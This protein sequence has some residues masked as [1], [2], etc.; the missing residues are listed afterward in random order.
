LQDQTNNL[1]NKAA[2]FRIASAQFIVSLV[3]ALLLLVTL[4]VKAAYSAMLGGTISSVATVYMGLRIF[5]RNYNTAQEML[6]A[7]YVSETIK[8]LFVVALFCMVFILIDVHFL[9][10]VFTYFMTIIVFALA[11]IWPVLGFS[12]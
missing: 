9:S 2:V 6:S 10:F 11:L 8:I 12:K 4:G 7:F 5:S 3:I 1:K